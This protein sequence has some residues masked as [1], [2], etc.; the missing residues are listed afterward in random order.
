MIASFLTLSIVFSISYNWGYQTSQ[1]YISAIVPD[2]DGGIWCATAGGIIRYDPD[3]G[4][5]D[6]L[7]YPDQLPWISAEDLYVSDTLMWVATGG[8]GLALK[9]GDSWTVFSAFEGIPGTGQVHSVWSGGGYIWAGTDGGLSRGNTDGF[10]PIDSDLT[11]GA[12]TAGEVTDITSTGNTLYL[13]TDRG[14]FSLDL[15][16]SVFNPDSWTS[17]E[18]STLSLGIQNIYIASPDSI[19]GYGSG[20]VSQKVGS[21]WVRLLDYSSSADS[22]VTGLLVTDDGLIAACRQIILYNGSGWE[23]Y[24][25]G[26]PEVSFAS[27][28]SLVS[29]RIWCGYGLRDENCRDTGRGLGYLDNGSWE[30][31]H[32]PGMGGPSCYQVAWDEDRIY[33]GSHRIGLMAYYPDSGWVNFSNLTTDMPRSLRTYSAAKSD[34]A[35]IWTGSYHW[36]LTWIDDRG[37]YSMNDDTV[38]TFVSD[39][40]SGI[41]SEVVQVV[42]PLFNNQ[43]IMLTSQSGA[44][45][46]AQ[47]AFWQTP[48]EPSGIVAVSG[49]PEDGDLNW[50]TRT[51]TDGLAVKNIQMLFPTGN[52]SL[53]IAFASDGGCQLLVHG[54]DPTDKSSD[55]W[56]PGFGQAYTTSWGLPSNQVFCFA[57]EADGSVLAGTGNGLCRWNGSVF[58]EVAGISGSVKSMQVDGNGVIW[59]MTEDA[60]YSVDGAS[61]TKFN[62]SNSIYIPFNRMENEFSTIDP[63]SGTVLFSSLAGIWSISSQQDQSESPE[64]VFYPQPYLPAEETL[65]IVWSGPDE[66]VEVKFFSL[67]GNYLGSVSAGNR[68]TWT[69]DGT[70]EGSS[71]AS[72]IYIVLVE[73][74]SES[75]ISKIAVVR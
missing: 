70:L 50:T 19:F 74:P 33:I 61:V 25:S 4:W 67:T 14:V 10:L 2:T 28:L 13:A 56:Y 38:I 72:G 64:P 26:Y 71:L 49:E 48:D 54:G 58:V 27:C 11:G 6:S 41:P 47:E 29:G 45:L 51:D 44:L 42:S 22:V 16:G 21:S 36:G 53:W 39:S 68:E 57:R 12:F 46:A 7:F 34:C 3:E 55:T 40:L 73:S 37:T 66:P 15:G 5:Q 75:V 69:W 65:R 8:G 31:V 62:S 20:G 23:T 9:Q 32:V 30:I 60:V 52:D 1:S 59:C 17:F 63:S 35:G 24:G 18:D 43:I